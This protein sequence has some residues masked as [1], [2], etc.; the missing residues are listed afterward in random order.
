MNR[1]YTTLFLLVSVDGK[2]STGDV[3]AMDVDKDYPEIEGLKEGLKQYYDLEMETDLFSFNTGRVFAKVGVNEK[4]DEPEKLPVSF[5]VLD[6]EP[7]LIDK[8]VVYL[9]KKTKNLIIATTNED[10]PAFAL[11]DSFEN[12][13]VLKYENK[14]DFRD[15]FEKIRE[16]FGAERMTI[17]SGG[18][19]NATL[20]REGLIDRVLLVVAPALVGGKDTATLM[21]GESLHNTSDLGK[22][23]TLELAQAKPLQNS[24]LLLEYKVR[25]RESEPAQ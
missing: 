19:L 24:Y 2:I 8:G 5:V 1:P 13:H 11:K 22:I 23:V 15:L 7:H 6:N 14:I 25:P 17:Q 3:D 4:T 18:T 16:Q 21:D 20:V 12:I 10:H 9:A